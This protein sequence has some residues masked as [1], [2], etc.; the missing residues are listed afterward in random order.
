MKT[1]RD[2]YTKHE[3]GECAEG[4]VPSPNPDWNISVVD[5]RPITKHCKYWMD[6]KYGVTRHMRAC[7]HYKPIKQ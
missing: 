7:V 1:A 3:C 6:G 5:G 2:S 4:E